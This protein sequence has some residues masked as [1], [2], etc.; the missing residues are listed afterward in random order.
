LVLEPLEE[1]CL[2]STYTVDNGNDSGLGTLRQA[3]LDSNA[4]PGHNEILIDTFMTDFGGNEIDVS[5]P[6][7]TITVPVWIHGATD[8]F[9]DNLITVSGPAGNTM[10]GLDIAAGFSRVEHLI[11]RD[12]GSDGIRLEGNG[13]S[14]IEN[15]LLQNDQ[16]GL[17]IF[18]PDNFVENNTIKG[19]EADGLL[20]SGSNATGNIVR[21]DN[22]GF[23]DDPIESAD[24][25]HQDGV[26]IE[27]GASDNSIGTPS[28]APNKIYSSDRDGVHISGSDTKGNVVENNQIYFTGGS[29]VFIGDGA[30][31]NS[32]GDFL[33]RVRNIIQ[34]AGNGILITGNGTNNNLV[35][36]N[37]IG[38]DDAGFP[39]PIG[40]G[41]RIDGGASNNV[42]GEI[43]DGTPQ[44]NVISYAQGN[45]VEIRDSGTTNN[46]VMANLIGT[47]PDGQ[48]ITTSS[49]FP[50]LQ[51]PTG[52]KVDGVLI[53]AGADNNTIG[54]AAQD[55]GNVISGNLAN[56][57]EITDAGTTQNLVLGN[58]IGTDAGDTLA[59][60]NSLDGVLIAAGASDNNVGDNSGLTHNVIVAN[61]TNGVEIRDPG[62]TGNS[63]VADFIGTNSTNSDSLG[64]QAAG[65]LIDNQAGNNFVGGGGTVNVVS[66]NQNGV[67]ISDAM[68]NQVL[69]NW[70]GASA[71]GSGVLGNVD[72]VLIEGGALGNFVGGLLNGQA[73]LIVGNSIGVDI[74]DPGT[75]ENVVQNNF[76]GISSSNARLGNVT[77]VA[78]LNG[79]GAFYSGTEDN[80]TFVDGNTV[81]V[82]VISA[83]LEDGVDISGAG[84]TGNHISNNAIGTDLNGAITDPDG[85]PGNGDELGNGGNGIRIDGGASSNSVDSGNAISGNSANGVELLGPGTN[86]NAIDGN[87]IGTDN[88]GSYVLQNGGDGVLIS[89]GAQNNTVGGTDVTQRNII[90]GNNNGI[91]LTDAGT[92]GNV[93]ENNYIGTDNSGE[94]GLG[95]SGFGVSIH[96]GASSNTIGAAGAGNVISDNSA[97]VDLDGPGTSGN[98]IDANLIGTDALG[99]ANLGNRADGVSIENSASNNSIEGGNVIS[100]N[101]GNGVTIDGNFGP[102]TTGNIV[103]ANAIGTDSTHTVVEGNLGDGVYIINGAAQNAIGGSGGGNTIVNNGL[104][105]VEIA[106]GSNN[107]VLDNVIGEQVTV[108]GVTTNMGNAGDGVLLRNGA[109]NNNIGAP[110][111]GNVIA[112]NGGN[113]VTVG[114]SAADSPTFGNSIVFN[115]IVANAKLGIDLANDG[116]T[117]NGVNPGTGPNDSQNFPVIMSA[118][119]SSIGTAFLWS[120]ASTPNTPFTI[121]FFANLQ[122]DPSGYGQGEIPLAGTFSAS[123]VTDATGHLTGIFSVALDLSG[124]YITATATNLT[125]GDTSEFSQDF[126]V[127]SR[128]GPAGVL[129]IVATNAGLP[130]TS[131]ITLDQTSSG[132]VSVM[133]DGQNIQYAPAVVTSVIVQ[134]GTGD[135][136]NILRTPAG[137]PVTVDSSGADFV[138]LGNR[139][140]GMQDIMS[141]VTLNTTQFSTV[142][143]DD[144]AD[145]MARSVSITSAAITG[146]APANI[147]FPCNPSSTTIMGG[148]GANTFNVQ[149]TAAGTTTRLV[150]Q[151]ADNTA[152]VGQNGSVQGILGDLVL[153]PGGTSWSAL[154][155]DDSADTT[156]RAVTI[157][158]TSITGLAPAVI[159]YAGVT[160]L[161]VA[162]GSGGNRFNVFSVEG[163]HATSLVTGGNDIVMIG[164]SGSVQSVM[165]N[166]TIVGAG[167]T[168]VVDDSADPTPRTVT[169]TPTSITGLSPATI[170][171]SDIS[172]LTVD[173]GFGGNTFIVTNTALGTNTTVNTGNGVDTAYVEGT[174]GPLTVNTQQGSTTNTFGGFEAVYVGRPTT[175]GFT[176]DGIQGALTVNTL[177]RQ[178][179]DWGNLALYDTGET[180][181]ETYTVTNNTILRSGAAPIYYTVNN[182]VFFNLGSGGNTF[183]VQSLRPGLAYWVTGGVGNDTFNV[184]DANNTLNGI[185]YQLIFSIQNP[186]SQVN[187]HDEG[188]TANYG[189]ALAS[190]ILH[191]AYYINLPA[192]RI[193]RS[194]WNQQGLGAAIWVTGP[195]FGT[196][197]LPLQGLVLKAGSGNNTF[198][199]QSLPP[200]N[201]TV[202][203]D[204]G[205]G[206]NTLQGPNQN[207][208]WQVTAPNA[209]SL[210]TNIKFAN[211]QNVIGGI[212]NDAFAFKTGGSLGGTLDGG[213]GTNTLDYSGF[214]GDVTVDL[215]LAIA[216]GIANGLANIQNVIG[217]QGNDLLVGDANSNVLLGGTG[218]NVIIGGAGSDQVAGG[219]GDNLLIGGTTSYDMNLAALQAIQK[220]WDDP[221]L[222]FDKRVNALKKGTTVNGQT[223][224][225]NKSTVQNDGAPDSLVGGAGRN[226]FIADSDDTIN[227]GSGPGANDRLTRI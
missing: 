88:T 79:A 89:G 169:I 41:V 63:V 151:L 97:G 162:G 214:V 20:I 135:T 218:R 113:G 83:N 1:R 120:L 226:W 159:T 206:T 21:G 119:V 193:L 170:F 108:N 200:G 111:L 115:Q 104:N 216:T 28:A 175:S 3:I 145:V 130:A 26:A 181:S 93:V 65:V 143:L 106:A 17:A 29:G 171:Y 185:I 127:N 166:L 211:V 180:A 186:G 129:T 96:G 32:I 109:T 35:V 209:G 122:R 38:F 219:G 27:N 182:E 82:N 118:A 224:I 189:Y 137:V 165:G 70:I 183:N 54:G 81:T 116:V 201:P 16:N 101:L 142:K 138:S 10:V 202:T 197:P 205:A 22:F 42:V 67:V 60:P 192:Y 77:G 207:N 144:S 51:V 7:P 52:N 150:T 154:I 57:V 30:N 124:G 91:E 33:G 141:D 157:T 56:G 74:T 133:L 139:T 62:T 76:I 147:F 80:R 48:Q 103:E 25:N 136:V 215:P 172:N 24:P 40:D 217:S 179:L 191:P 49:G 8:S 140:D 98:S 194:D 163:G 85:V 61:G 125:T 199:V 90:S 14:F 158:G 132:G 128:F 156:P 13:S 45:G 15:N 58:H 167:A 71:D 198:D 34:Y 11:I 213:A 44:G 66:N 168:L 47:T 174:T 153:D 39:G 146:L 190:V 227:N 123:T 225:L 99:V 149:S 95:N 18:A 161:T 155:V 6:L 86:G 4:N 37:T 121:Q 55:D 69:G 164:Q 195:L 75:A 160:N 204:G 184:G 173:G 2:L 178:N 134:S 31:N 212:G 188:S 117:P 148:S 152:N 50:G 105:G 114:N 84:T 220:V 68:D 196:P 12:F 78:I 53:A 94:I 5:T 46:Q 64:N 112:Y 23:L 36:D 73:N 176:L 208:S 59:L 131:T 9:G 222:S 102:S 19:N 100:F 87:F 210:D 203:L 221:I 223:V 177:A 110:D 187:L 107:S 72:G 43:F 126:Y 92:Q